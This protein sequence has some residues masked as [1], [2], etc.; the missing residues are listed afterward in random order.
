[1]V[2]NSAVKGL[3]KSKL[4][5]RNLVLKKG[6]D[7]EVDGSSGQLRV[8]LY[9]GSIHRWEMKRSDKNCSECMGD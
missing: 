8:P 3:K 6:K 4:C 9:R 5:R 1:M 7:G 2:F